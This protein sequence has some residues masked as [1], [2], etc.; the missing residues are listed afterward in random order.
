MTPA[1]YALAFLALVAVAMC[2]Q[3]AIRLIRWA[4]ALGAEVDREV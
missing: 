3:Q 1:L 2:I 4:R